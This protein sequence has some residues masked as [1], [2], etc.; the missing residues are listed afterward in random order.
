MAFDQA[1]LQAP[2]AAQPFF[3][4][5]QNSPAVIIGLNQNAYSEVNLPLLQEKGI[6][7]VR[8]VTGGG[9]VY[10]DLQNLNYTIAGRIKDLER[11]F[12]SYMHLV[13]DALCKLGVKASLSGR[14]DILVDGRKCSGYAK[15]VWRDR[16]M[17]HGTLMFDVDIQDMITALSAPGSK[18]SAAG[19]AS[20][21]SRVA[22]L[23]EYLPQFGSIDGF[24]SALQDILAAGGEEIPVP[25]AMTELAARDA[26]AKFR[27]WE[28]NVG[29]SPAADFSSGG[30][31]SCG[32]VR[33]SWSLARGVLKSL[34]FSGDFI[35]NKTAESL[36]AALTG[37]RMEAGALME[38]MKHCGICPADCFDGMSADEFLGLL[39]VR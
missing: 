31:F 39:G 26:D 27:T 33:A 21:R 1:C 32:T 11:D 9:A 25:A 2:P 5:W 28:W 20:V 3:Y 34:S 14:N 35:G 29:R 37:C 38:A 36:S 22:N 13:A 17:I 18:F 23:K 30:K 12:P 7:L 19:V 4:L 15:R 6:A 8:R 16:I 24:R 10:H